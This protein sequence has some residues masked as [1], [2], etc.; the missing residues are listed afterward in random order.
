MSERLQQAMDA[1]SC[2]FQKALDPQCEGGAIRRFFDGLRDELKRA[3]AS[4]R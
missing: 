3:E 1:Q 4:A 2:S